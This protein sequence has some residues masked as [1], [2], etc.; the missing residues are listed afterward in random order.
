MAKSQ[1]ACAIDDFTEAIR[2][3]PEDSEGYWHRGSAFCDLKEYE[4]AIADFDQAIRR[5]PEESECLYE[6]G[7]ALLETKKYDKAIADF[8]RVIERNP[9]TSRLLA[10]VGLPGTPRTNTSRRSTTS[11]RRSASILAIPPSGLTAAIRGHPRETSTRPSP[12]TTKPFG[13]IRLKRFERRRRGGAWK[14]KGE[15]DKA[16]EDLSEAIRLDPRCSD[17][18]KN[19]ASLG[20]INGRR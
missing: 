13:S 1:T 19:A 7:D 14:A 2:L 15:F 18:L 4:K 20:R 3:H 12:I 8:D 6:R 16:I 11:A 17:A 5:N 10:S 9:K